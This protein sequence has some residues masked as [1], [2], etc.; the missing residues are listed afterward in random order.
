[1]FSFFSRHEQATKGGEG[2]NVGD[3]GYPSAGKIAWLLWGGDAG[4][5]WATRKVK[6]IK[7]V[8]E[9]FGKCKKKKCKDGK[10]KCVKYSKD[11]RPFLS[12][13][14]GD[15]L[16]D[17]LELIGEEN[18]SNEWELISEEE[19]DTTKE[20]F[21]Q[22]ANPTKSDA[23]PN[24]KSEWGDTGLYKVR[25]VYAK[26]SR[27]EQKS[28]SRKFCTHMIELASSGIE[29]R[30]EDIIKMSEEGVNSQFAPKGKSTYNL[31][32]YK[33]G[34]NCHHGWLRRIYFRKKDNKG[35]FLPNKGLEN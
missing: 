19:V 2:Y 31:F 34:V 1:M 6:E 16:L 9:G 33:G 7:A 10:C 15:E 27:K 13:E 35:R 12:D 4:F 22:F 24:E 14:H 25:Y 3:D 28:S 17:Y 23:K 26:T 11:D 20:G 30:Y 29:Y 21:H 5:S 32:K 8:E 18:D